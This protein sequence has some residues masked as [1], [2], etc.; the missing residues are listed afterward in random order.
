MMRIVVLG[1]FG[2]QGQAAVVDLARS[3]DVTDIICVDVGPGLPNELTGIQ[4]MD[5]VRLVRVDASSKSDL[6]DLFHRD[7]DAVIDL[8]PLPLMITAFTAAVE[9][10]VPIVS[11]NYAHSVRHLDGPAREAG[12]IVMPE[13]GLD[14]GIDLI[15]IGHGV[16][17][18]DQLTKLN[19][20]CGGIP[21][22][23]AADNPL[24]Y[25]I[26]WNWDMVLTSSVRD[27]VF[28]R[29]GRR[30]EIPA[31]RQHESDAVHT[32]SFPGLG[33]LE[34]IPNGN[35]VFYTDLLGLTEHITETGRYALRYPGWSSFW[36]PM[37]RLGFLETE[38]IPGLAAPISPRDILVHH[39]EPRLQYQR[40]EKDL[41]VMHNIFE[42]TRGGRPKRFISS[43][44][45]ERDLN[46]G[47][48][49]MSQ[50]V[51]YTTSIV[52]QMIARG[53]IVDAGLRSPVT[54]IPYEPFIE[55][56]AARGIRTQE[57]NYWLD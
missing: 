16:R 1:G 2:L 38:P 45:I 55:A 8:L 46:T 13:C 4:G 17:R 18:F 35:A 31:D 56:L 6:V 33:E 50:G 3:N 37:K 24:R 48:L 23:E 51:G 39:L 36:A 43:L 5:K 27:S 57:E 54:D 20:Y 7:V 10:S 47:L 44:L 28:I 42:G 52:A 32:I 29:N 25:K 49:A 53:H 9:A 41:A 11:T 34:A 19:S 12:V 15:L 14:P 22:P 21:E 40:N 30:L 26:S